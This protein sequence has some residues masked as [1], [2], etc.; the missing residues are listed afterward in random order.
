MKTSEIIYTHQDLNAKTNKL[1]LKFKI[2][3]KLYNI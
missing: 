1:K 3:E 2:R